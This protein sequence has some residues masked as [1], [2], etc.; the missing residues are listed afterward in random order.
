MKELSKDSAEVHPRLKST[1]KQKIRIYIARV[2]S[3]QGD[4]HY[5]A[6][7]MAIGVFV[8]ITPTIPFHT[9]AALA[10]AFIL[11]GSKP[12]AAVG[13]WFSNPITIPFFYLGSYRLGTF[14]LNVSAPFD[15]KYDS[16][17][18]LLKLGL[19]V[20]LAMIVGG[21]IIGFPAG[22]VAYIITL[23]AFKIIRSRKK[24][25]P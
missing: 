3:L 11:R 22:I 25:N 17:S 5:V 21:V 8:G 7:G 1:L 24:Y 4:P 10:L 19:G 23:K 13:V 2:K 18:E 12:A 15:P 14:L 20:T 9:I 6:K 16:L